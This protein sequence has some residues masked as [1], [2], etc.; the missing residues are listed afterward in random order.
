MLNGKEAAE[1]QN[2][3]STSSI[4]LCLNLS[5]VM[6][7]I[8]HFPF[9]ILDFDLELNMYWNRSFLIICVDGHSGCG[10]TS[11]PGAFY[12]LTLNPFLIPLNGEHWCGDGFAFIQKA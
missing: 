6:Y 5:S 2:Y 8:L 11:V 10:T 12:D 9:K 7:R 1:D 3:Y 4:R